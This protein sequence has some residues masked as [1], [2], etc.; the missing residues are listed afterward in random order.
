MSKSKTSKTSPENEEPTEEYIVEKII[1]SRINDAGVK[2][3]L[4]KWIGYVLRI[5]YFECNLMFLL[6][7]MTTRITPGSPKKTSIV[8]V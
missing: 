3:Y 7:D 6:A 2:E 1:D 5:V 4:L 8:R